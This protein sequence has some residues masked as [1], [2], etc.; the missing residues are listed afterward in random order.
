M[1]DNKKK[2]QFLFKNEDKRTTIMK[3]MEEYLNS[4]V[5]GVESSWRLNGKIE[6]N[7]QKYIE[8]AEENF[9]EEILQL[10]SELRKQSELEEDTYKKDVKSLLKLES[11]N[12]QTTLNIYIN[13]LNYFDMMNNGEDEDKIAKKEKEISLLKE[14]LSPLREQINDFITNLKYKYLY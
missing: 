5:K 14:S 7:T 1:G 12:S 9:M 13:T 10:N 2:Y 4:A 8:H 11:Q 6:K 3:E